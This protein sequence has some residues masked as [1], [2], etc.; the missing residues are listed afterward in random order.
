MNTDSIILEFI[1]IFRF[2]NVVMDFFKSK[3]HCFSIYEENTM[4]GMSSKSSREEGNLDGV[5]MTLSWS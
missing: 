3:I 4:S 2:D 1:D 5:Y